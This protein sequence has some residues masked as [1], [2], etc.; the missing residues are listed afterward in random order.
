MLSMCRITFVRFTIFLVLA[1]AASAQLQTFGDLS[2]SVP[3]GYAYEFVPG[4]EHA[5]MGRTKPGRTKPGQ[6]TFD[7][8]FRKELRPHVTSAQFPHG[9]TKP[10]RTHETGARETGSNDV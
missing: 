3:A 4:D 10:G 5:T 9:R 7:C 1:V 2:F 6:T 8:G